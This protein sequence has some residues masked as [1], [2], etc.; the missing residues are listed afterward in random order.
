MSTS[1]INIFI[2]II[3]TLIFLIIVLWSV[4]INKAQQA[5]STA[6]WMYFIPM[7]ALY[8][9]GH[10]LR[11]FRLWTLMERQGGGF[12]EYFSINS[13][14]FLGINVIPLRLGEFLRPHLFHQKLQI[15]WTRS[16][17]ALFLERLLDIG[18]LFL[19]LLGV[20]FG[21]QLPPQGILV[22]EINVIEVGQRGSGFILVFGSLVGMFV[23]FSGEHLHV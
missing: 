19:L 9:V 6:Q 20:G 16:L 3:L 4:D 8:G 5:L 13:I 11:T 2:A 7:F 23:V 22:Q 14:G 21:V 17:S 1:K 10:T 12:L 15:P 18:M